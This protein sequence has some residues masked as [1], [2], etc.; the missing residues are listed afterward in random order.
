MT[1]K[2][3]YLKSFSVGSVLSYEILLND[4]S[5]HFFN[6]E[7]LD[8]T[9]YVLINKIYFLYFDKDVWSVK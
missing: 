3:A 2:A 7:I 9:F 6:K 8:L 1:N 5:T 4:H